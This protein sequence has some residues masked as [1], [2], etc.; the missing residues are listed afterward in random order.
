MK[1]ILVMMAMIWLW[2]G[3]AHRE[4]YSIHKHTKHDVETDK[5]KCAYLAE[6]RVP[7]AQPLVHITINAKMSKK[8]RKHLEAKRR[9]AEQQKEWNRDRRVKKIRDLCLKAKGWRWRYV[10]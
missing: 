4:Y 8:E 10:E 1:S 6:S 2:S 9:Q 7:L 3:C 5:A